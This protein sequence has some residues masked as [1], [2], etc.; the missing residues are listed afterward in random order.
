LLIDVK[1]LKIIYYSYSV[2]LVG[3]GSVG[4]TGAVG[5]VGCGFTVVGAGFAVG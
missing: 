2:V 5:S 3:A 4:V 1:F